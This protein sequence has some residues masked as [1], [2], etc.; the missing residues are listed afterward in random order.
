MTLPDLFAST[1]H[2]RADEPALEFHGE[3]LTFGDLDRRSN[4][5]ARLLLG[6]G[7][8]AGDRLGV[9][10]ANRVEF[11]DLFLACIKTGIMVLPINILYRERELSHIAADAEPKAIVA[12]GPVP[13]VPTFI[14]VDELRGAATLSGESLDNPAGLTADTALSI[15][16]TSGTTGTAKGAVLSHGNFV[17]NAANLLQ[18]WRITSADRLLLPLPLFHVHGLGNG[19]CCWLASGCRMRLLER[20]EADKAAGEFLAFRPSV[21]FA[22]PTIYVRLLDLPADAAREVGGHMRLFVSGSAPL[23]AHVHEAFRL[24]FGHAILERYGMTET[25]MNVGNPYDGIRRPGTVGLPL[26]GVSVRIVNAAGGE[27]AC[28]EVGEV[29]VRGANVFARYW[30]RDDATRAAFV[31]DWFKTGDLGVRSD[32]GYISLRGRATD[33]IISSGFNIYPREIEEVIL[34]SPGVREAVVVGAP[35]PVRGE[36]PIAYVVADDAYDEGV[37]VETLKR[38]LASFKMPRVF[39]KVDQL[40]RTAL[41]KVQKHL[42]PAPGRD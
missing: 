16:Y 7:F 38:S 28:D 25:L 40:P 24:A 32:D 39:M 14:H 41:G 19:V 27:A 22:V 12:A 30:R 15:I 2:S 18:A 8:R 11:I 20:F 17:A 3:R 31:D 42:L 34:D 33:L 26:P 29:W 4:Q 1:F 21:F 5:V 13:G 10:L 6:K 23:P 35:D 9:Y 37:L 36:V